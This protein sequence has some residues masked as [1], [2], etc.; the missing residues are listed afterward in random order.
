MCVCSRRSNRRIVPLFYFLS[1]DLY[2]LGSGIRSFLQLT[3]ETIQALKKCRIVYV[4]HDDQMV[5]DH[6]KKYCTNVQ[7]LAYMYQ[8]NTIRSKVYRDISEMLVSEAVK[9]S[10]VGF[11]V[12]GHPLF[13]VSATEY[14]LSLART[15]NLSISILPAVSSFDTLLC[16]LEIDYGYGIQIFDATSM[17]RMNWFPNPSIPTL[18]FQLTTILN[19]EIVTDEPN[20]SVLSPLVKHLS[21]VY[22][23]HHLCTI[24]HSAAHLLETPSKVN[25]K[26]EEM[27]RNNNKIELWKRPTLY[28]P[29]LA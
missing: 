20:E 10:N 17:V 9:Q 5:I 19:D 7:D 15:K 14:T 27:D 11:V 12:H 18:I 1:T 25:I 26:L 28:V 13:L 23:P 24:I 6:I 21:K 4:L 8:G 29:S 2:I 16:D 3:T 22:P